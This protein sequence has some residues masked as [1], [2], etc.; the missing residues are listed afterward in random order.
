MGWLRWE[1]DGGA[2]SFEGAASN[3]FPSHGRDGAGYFTTMEFTSTSVHKCPENG[4]PKLKKEYWKEKKKSG[5]AQ[6]YPLCRQH[7]SCVV[8]MCRRPKVAME[9]SCA[10]FESFR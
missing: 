4:G 3:T 7:S 9:V 1:T 2:L 5:G 8:T 6:Q 10:V